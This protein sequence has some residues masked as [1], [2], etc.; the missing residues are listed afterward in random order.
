M[1]PNGGFFTFGDVVRYKIKVTDPEDGDIDCEDVI[2]QPALGHD[3]HAHPYDQYRGCE[4]AIPINGDTGHI[5]ANIFGVITVTYTDKGA[6]GVDPLTSQEVLILQPKRKEAEY[7]AK[8]GRLEGST[9]T[10]DPGVEVEETEDTDG[11]QNIGFAEKDDWFSFDPTNLTGIDSIRV[12]GASQ[13]GGTVDIR[14]GAPDGDSIGS[15][16]IPAGGWQSWAN[17]DLELPENVTTETGPL[18]FVITAGQ[19]NVNW[20]QFIGKGVTDNESPQVEV[21]TTATTG[22]APLA[23]SFTATATDP[24]GDTPLTYAWDFGDGSTADTAQTSHTYTVPGRYTATVTV[25]DARGAQTVEV[26]QVS[27]N[28]PGLQCLDG[29]SDG[30]DGDALDT[31]RWDQSVRVN[32]DLRVEDGALV[33]P[34]SATDIYGTNNGAVPNL[35]LQDL[36]EGPFT[37]TTRLT[38]NGAE[39]Y[40]QGGLLI[41]GDDD[42]YAKMVFSGRSTSG[43]DPASRVFQFIRE[44]AGAPNEVNASM[45]PAVG[46]DYPST[47]WVRFVSD[48]E[49]LTASYSSNGTDFTG[50]SETKSLEGIDNP[51]IGLFALQGAGRTQ[52]PV[53]VEFDYF[54]ITPDDTVPPV[55]PT[56]EFDGSSID[57]CRWEIV[58]PDPEHMR[59][60]D[61]HLE[62]DA[63]TGDIYGTDNGTPS[64][65]VVQE[66]DG[67]WT[68]ETK[69]DAS[70]L[71]RQYEQGGLIVYVDDDNYVKFDIS[72]RNNPGSA[73]TLGLE[74]LSEVGGVIQNPQPA[75][76]VDQAVWHLRLAKVGNDFTASYS[77]DGEEWTEFPSIPNAPAAASGK[78]GLFALGTASTDNRTVTFDYFRV[79]G[80]EQPEPVEVTPAAVTFTDA[81]GTENDTYTVPA[82]QG[83]EYLVGGKVVAAGSHKATG[84]V[85]VTARAMEGF[86]LAEGA[87]TEWTFTFTTGGGEPEPVEVTPAAV[88]FTDAAGTK[89]DTYTVPAVQGVEYLVGGKVVAAGTYKGAGAVTVTARAAEGFVLAE[90]ASTQ[91]TFTFTG[92]G[93]QVPDPTLTHGFFLTNDW[94]GTTHYAFQYGRA[95]DEVFIGDWDADGTDS[96]AVRRGNAF[97]VSNAPRG[98]VADE[99]FHYGR[100]GDTVLVGDWNGDGKDTLAVRRGREYFVKNSLRGGPA[101]VVVHYGRAGDTV[102]V[103]DWDGDGRDTLAVRRGSQY[104]VKNS[105]AGGRADVEFHYGRAGDVTLAGDWDGDGKDTLAVRRGAVYYAKNSLAGGPADVVVTYGRATDE[106]FVGDWNGDGRDS[107]GL[108]R[109]PQVRVTAMAPLGQVIAL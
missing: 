107:L 92:G 80:D 5:G 26:V 72:A 77:A 66:L 37:A 39:A 59:V 79:V 33:I 81:S 50:M 91:W 17:Y 88:T 70:T 96:I 82:V 42:N 30:F 25:T 23:V 20:V 108:R 83:V 103:G 101:D 6:E 2:V 24:D 106:A 94:S 18:Y 14:T 27:V 69:V 21:T 63:T 4:G 1:P 43:S 53:D 58:R 57:G 12:R 51:K 64:N 32:Q 54:H 13:P 87:R 109:L 55:D 19:A 52:A 56:D 49:N 41:Y 44:E 68:V 38:L 97:Y 100:A 9:S 85:T 102:L 78:V 31:G 104:F 36:P 65:F 73:L 84:T 61:G 47:V 3:E 99:V 62:L 48:G 67:D 75:A 40:Q 60:V 35:V 71:T 90:G 7:F 105:I 29:R 95:T 11:G 76:A 34:T 98:G 8:T 46:G 16:T 45:S 86:V 89:D 93:G 22:M 15:V 10:G 28:A 74:A